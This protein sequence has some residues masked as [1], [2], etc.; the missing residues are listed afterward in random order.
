MESIFTNPD[1]PRY[2][3]RAFPPYRFLPFQAEDE[4]R[5]GHD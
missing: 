1:L 2:T 5:Q 3:Q 4:D